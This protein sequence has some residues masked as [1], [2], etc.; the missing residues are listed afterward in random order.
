MGQSARYRFVARRPLTG[1]SPAH[2]DSEARGLNEKRELVGI[3]YAASTNTDT[4]A[5]AHLPTAA[6]SQSAGFLNLNSWLPSGDQTKPSIA[7]AINENGIV[8]GQVGTPFNN[9]KAEAWQLASTITT[10]D[11]GTL[12]GGSYSIAYAINNASSP[13]IVGSS[14]RTTP[15]SATIAPF[16]LTFSTSSGTGT[17]V[18]L[19]TAGD[20]IESVAYDV[21]NPTGSNLARIV[22]LWTEHRGNCTVDATPCSDPNTAAQWQG[23]TR[24]VLLDL[25]TVSEVEDVARGNNEAGNIVGWGFLEL[26][27]P[28]SDICR[29]HITFHS[30]AGAT[31]VDLH[32]D[33]TSPL[34]DDNQTF[35]N[36]INEPYEDGLCLQAVG[37]NITTAD[38]ALWER[39]AAGDWTYYAL[40]SLIG[41]HC[42]GDGLLDIRQAHD[43][44]GG[45]LIAVTAD[46]DS[47]SSQTLRAGVLY[48]LSDLNLDGATDGADLGILLNHWSD[49]A[50][51]PGCGGSLPCVS[52]LNCDALVNGTD[53]GVLLLLYGPD[54]RPD[55]DAGEGFAGGG[56]SASVAETIS[57]PE[58]QVLIQGLLAAGGADAVASI[59][60]AMLEAA[61]E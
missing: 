61:G 19:V 50:T 37:N 33:L 32:L 48:C 20:H 2:T 43:I 5:F 46:I 44:N 24:T 45:G 11:L 23:T 26:P 12:G 17:M 55:C 56:G 41:N 7:F 16:R 57:T 15:C 51:S 49:P 25:D 9:G 6:Y 8:V 35:G 18:E 58:Y 29:Q 59:I 39:D 60:E 3:S 30:S 13:E 21:D 53:L 54:C 34:P 42:S 38:G 40:N 47:S 22:G 31:L 10:H 36:A 27:S 1:Q 52:D 14:H 28:P 4:R